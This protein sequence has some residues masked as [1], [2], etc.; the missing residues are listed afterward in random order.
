[1]FPHLS[2]CNGPLANNKA[3]QERAHYLSDNCCCWNER[4]IMCATAAGKWL[5]L[6]TCSTLLSDMQSEQV[7]PQLG[8]RRNTAD[9]HL[10]RGTDSL[11]SIPAGARRLAKAGQGGLPALFCFWVFPS[12]VT[13]LTLAPWSTGTKS[14]CCH[15]VTARWALFAPLSM[16]FVFFGITFVT[17]HYWHICVL[18][19]VMNT[20]YLSYWIVLLR[21]MLLESSMRIQSSSTCVYSQKC[22]IVALS[23]SRYTCK[24]LRYTFSSEIIF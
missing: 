6:C 19:M 23:L 4:G 15:C 12:M 13:H 1:M 7:G 20:D 18:K 10:L 24:R 8:S 22:E 11:R 5:L 21:Y 2:Q 9:S 3:Q 16:G 14:R 17:K